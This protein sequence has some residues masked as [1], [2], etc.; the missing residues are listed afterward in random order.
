M[1]SLLPFSEPIPLDCKVYKYFPVFSST[2][3]ETGWSDKAGDGSLFSSG[4][5][6]FDNNPES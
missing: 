5:V 4:Q 1:N 3:D 6:G 2:L